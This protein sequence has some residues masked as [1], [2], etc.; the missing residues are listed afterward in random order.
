MERSFLKQHFLSHYLALGA[1]R[2]ALLAHALEASVPT[3]PCVLGPSL[4]GDSVPRP[5]GWQGERAL[6]SFA[7]WRQLFAVLEVGV[8]LLTTATHCLLD[9]LRCHPAPP[10]LE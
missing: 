7:R 2:E 1:G 8:R 4:H 10:W 6:R 9:P 5:Q 3:G